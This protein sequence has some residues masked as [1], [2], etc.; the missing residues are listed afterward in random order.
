MYWLWYAIY[1]V[2]YWLQLGP[3]KLTRALRRP[4]IALAAFGIRRARRYPQWY[5]DEQKD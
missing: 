2:G 3:E 5:A 1:F 4:G